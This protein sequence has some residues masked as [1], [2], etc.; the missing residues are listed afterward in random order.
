MLNKPQDIVIMLAIIAAVFI[1]V[2]FGITSIE[3]Q[4]ANINNNTFFSDISTD[5]SSE[6]GIQSTAASASNVLDPSNQTVTSEASEENIITQGLAS[7]RSVS[8]TYKS[9]E[10]IGYRSTNMLSIDPIY[11]TLFI[12][13]YTWVRGR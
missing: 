9:V 5:I 1:T 2:G 7:L 10:K 4:G 8:A 6:T 11:I 12:I 3:E 13:T